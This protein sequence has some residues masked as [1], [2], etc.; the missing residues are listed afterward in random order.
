MVM[1]ARRKMKRSVMWEKIGKRKWL[2]EEK[3]HRLVP[4]V[5]SMALALGSPLLKNAASDE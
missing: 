1:S 2:A 5:S 3:K 4:E